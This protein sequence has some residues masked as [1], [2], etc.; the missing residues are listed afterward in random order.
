M[1]H[2]CAAAT[3][4]RTDFPTPG[5]PRSTRSESIVMS[6]SLRKRP[7]IVLMGCRTNMDNGRNVSFCF[8][9]S[10]S[11]P[12]STDVFVLDSSKA[13]KR[14]FNVAARISCFSK[15]EPMRVIWV[16][17]GCTV[18]YNCGQQICLAL[19]LRRLRA[20]PHC[21]HLIP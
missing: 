12:K 3:K 19:L 2:L 5:E 18:V 1:R 16:S 7:N 4:K 17:S 9:R 20:A 13:S 6:T 14:G 8:L 21:H 11:M 10:A 15:V